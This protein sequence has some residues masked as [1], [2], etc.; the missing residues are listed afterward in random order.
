VPAA[1]RWEVAGGASRVLTDKP[2]GRLP[3]SALVSA[4]P[5]LIP[6]LIV[7]VGVAEILKAGVHSTVNW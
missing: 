2:T 5:A 3:A 6:K 1:C 7:K 4:T